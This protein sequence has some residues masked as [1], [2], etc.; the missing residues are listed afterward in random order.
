MF[1]ESSGA[2]KKRKLIRVSIRS[3]ALV[4][5]KNK[6]LWES[7]D[8]PSHPRLDVSFQDEERVNEEAFHNTDAQAPPRT[9]GLRLWGAHITLHRFS[10]S[11]S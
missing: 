10:A 8:V 7:R 3:E 9:H 6:S 11:D 2:K 4:K 1:F 5:N